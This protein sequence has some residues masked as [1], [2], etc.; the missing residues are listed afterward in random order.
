MKKAP[1]KAEREHMG[2]VAD[3]G[4]VLCLMLGYGQTPAEVHHVRTGTGLTRASH[5]DT[6]PLCYP[7]HHRDGN[8][9]LHKMGRKAFEIEHGVTELAL[10]A[11]T[12][13]LLGVA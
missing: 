6:I 1:T 3:L 8:Q 13:R 4:C 9:S 5:Y 2:K 7:G 12:K 11:E 10:L